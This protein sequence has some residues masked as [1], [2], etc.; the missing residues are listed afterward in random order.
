VTKK[1]VNL[2]GKLDIDPAS[3][4]YCQVV[5]R[6]PM[7][8]VGDEL[9]HFGWNMCSSSH[10][11]PGASR[12]YLVVPGPTSGNIHILDAMNPA[13]PTMH[14]VLRGQDVATKTNLSG[15]HTVHCTPDGR[16]MLSMLGDGKGDAPGGFL[17]LDENFEIVGRWAGSSEGMSRFGSRYKLEARGA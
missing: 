13:A 11:V 12:R 16:I 10:G 3:K 5:H 4:T 6:L 14:K 1:V 8:N 2:F 9:H 17:V 7:P 15:P